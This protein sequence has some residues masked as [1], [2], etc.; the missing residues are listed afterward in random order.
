MIT[1]DAGL[2]LALEQ[3]EGV[4]KVLADLNAGQ[5]RTS[6]SWRAVMAEGWIEQARQLRRE[7]EEYT[8]LA[9]LEEAQADLWLA[10]EGRGIEEGSGPA[11][12]LTGLLDALRKGVQAVAELLHARRT[13]RQPSAGLKDA[14]DFWV[15][16]LQPDGLKI[17]I[18]L[19]DPPE[20]P[21]AGD[22]AVPDVHR[23]VR[24]LLGV[25]AWA[26][27]DTGD[28]TL[29]ERFPD[30]EERRALLNAV[31]PLV[32]RPRGAVESL[33]LSGRV[34][35]D[36]PP[37]R[38]MPAASLRID[39][40]LDRTTPGLVED[41]VGDLRAI[42]LDDRSMLIRSAADVREV[43]CTFDESLRDAAKEALDRRVKVTGVRQP[44]SGRRASAT[45]HVLRLELLDEPA[46][47][48]GPESEAG[49][50]IA[51]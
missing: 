11:S 22:G 19:P 6:A 48:A 21:G 17:G 18:R 13:G 39:R 46:A 7:I 26:A 36:G 16:A 1:T 12:V 3:L 20:Q 43:R 42:D 8:G 47:E 49:A 31:K 35:P 28:E 51:G 38:L 45:L 4:Y 27:S 10:V 50:A 2:R 32:P 25:A 15:V 9:A 23:A 30:S 41:H 33:T 37:I 5:P 44:R 14:C 24:E 40:A 29:D 34:V